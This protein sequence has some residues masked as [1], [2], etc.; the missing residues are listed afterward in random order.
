MDTWRRVEGTPSPL[1]CT[2]VAADQ[3]YNFALLSTTATA[4]RLRLF[5]TGNLA[6]PVLALNLDPLTNKSGNTWHCRGQCSRRRCCRVLQSA[7]RLAAG[8]D[9]RQHAL[10][11]RHGVARSLCTGDILPASL[12]AGRPTWSCGGWAVLPAQNA[13]A[14]DWTG[15]PWPLNGSE[16]LI[17]EMHVGHFTKNPNSG[18]AAARRGKY[19]GVIDKIPY[20]RGDLG[21]TAVELM[22]VFCFDPTSAGW[23]YMPISTFFPHPSYATAPRPGRR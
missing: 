14:T 11:A 15:V 9:R 5:A 17:Y 20:L 18:V 6:V 13:V 12:R 19:L 22:P 1:G 23:G 7:S 10:L 4:V 2:W 8:G 16:L 3:A 21:V